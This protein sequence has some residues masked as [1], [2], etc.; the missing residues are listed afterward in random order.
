MDANVCLHFSVTDG[1]IYGY[2]QRQWGAFR[3]CPYYKHIPLWTSHTTPIIPLFLQ[4]HQPTVSS[5]KLTK[6]LRKLKTTFIPA[7]PPTPVRHLDEDERQ[8]PLLTGMVAH[9]ATP[10]GP[11]LLTSS[12]HLPPTQQ[13]IHLSLSRSSE[14]QFLNCTC[15]SVIFF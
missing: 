6:R 5:W 11:V 12:S 14:T 2:W 4:P 1:S 7:K 8:G 13:V 15:E 3:V 9:G 10:Q